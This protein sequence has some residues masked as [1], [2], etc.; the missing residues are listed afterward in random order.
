MD[1]SESR[2]NVQYDLLLKLI[3][4]SHPKCDD[5][6]GAIFITGPSASGKTTFSK[7]LESVLTGAGY[8]AYVISI[9]DFY[10]DRDDI[11]RLEIEC[12][13]VPPD[14]E[15]FDY[16]TIAAFD[17]PFFREQ[18]Q[19]F[20]RREEVELPLYDFPAGKRITSG[21]R[22]RRRGND[23]LIV[24][25][26][27]AMNPAMCDGLNFSKKLNVY[28]CPFDIFCADCGEKVITTQQLRFMRRCILRIS[29]RDASVRRTM[30]MWNAVRLG[31]EKYIKPMKKYADFFFNSALEYEI[32][33]YSKRMSELRNNLETDE[34]AALSEI[35]NFD[36]LGCFLP[37]EDIDFPA[38]SIFGEFYMK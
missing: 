20:L 29:S 4:E 5:F 37:C 3:E 13:I 36:A 2:H 15:E 6:V 17:V 24:E 27:Q 25:G 14:A 22:L 33:F 10:R 34:L 32:A 31:E 9:D 1:I 8:N 35:I 18:M 26:I 30:G 28:I 19:A 21:K 38:G 7:R 12:G 16:E 23:L 11:H